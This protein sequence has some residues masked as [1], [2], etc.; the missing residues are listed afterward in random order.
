MFS[1]G[2]E[3]RRLEPVSCSEVWVPIGVARESLGAVGRD[4]G[5]NW[6]TS[7]AGLD[8][9]SFGAAG[10]D[11][12]CNWARSGTGGCPSPFTGLTLGD[13]GIPSVK[14]GVREP[15]PLRAPGT[16]ARSSGT[17]DVMVNWLS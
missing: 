16:G 11:A 6:G 8:S 10:R 1:G 7:A 12:G 17:G 2:I 5:R 4:E 9:E 13:G 3:G 15:L 14:R